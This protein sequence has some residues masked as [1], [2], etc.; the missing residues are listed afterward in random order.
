MRGIWF[1]LNGIYDIFVDCHFLHCVVAINDRSQVLFKIREAMKDDGE[2]WSETMAGIP[3]IKS[4]ENFFLDDEGIFWKALPDEVRYDRTLE[5]NGRVLSPIRRIH[6]RIDDLNQELVAAG[7]EILHQEKES[8][9]D[10]YSV[11]MVKTRMKL[12]R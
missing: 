10:D 9:Q 1:Y 6:E 5:W 2:L 3:R 11:W 4:G 12:L 8:P 7:F